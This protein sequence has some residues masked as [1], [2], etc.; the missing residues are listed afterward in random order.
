MSD[1]K[2]ILDTGRLSLRRFALSDAP[3]IVELL[4]DPAFIR[5]IA[6]RGVRTEDDARNYLQTGPLA[7][8]AQFGFG[9]FLVSLRT[10]STP[11]GMCGLLKRPELDDADIG[12][13]FLPAYCAKG[14]A[15][16]IAAALLSVARGH[17]GVERVVAIVNHDNAASIRLLQRLG[18][19]FEK[20]HAVPWHAE[21]LLL[22]GRAT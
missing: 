14:Y 7:S 13:A 16:E 8:Y 19:A 4:N 6:D 21:P 12:F 17:F 5:F 1:A 9:L 15:Y 18:F 22:F 10:D 20:K 11:I 3:F 2:N